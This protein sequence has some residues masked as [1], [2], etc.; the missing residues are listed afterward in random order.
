M[1]LQ[2]RRSRRRWKKSCIR[3]A[4]MIR[5]VLPS[6][7]QA[8]FPLVSS[9]L[10]SCCNG[11]PALPPSPKRTSDVAS[12]QPASCPPPITQVSRSLCRT[13]VSGWRTVG[14]EP[15]PSLWIINNKTQNDLTFPCKYS[16]V[17]YYFCFSLLLWYARVCVLLILMTHGWL[18]NSHL[19][20][21]YI[22]LHR[23][24]KYML[25]AYI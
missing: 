5:I 16:G 23:W 24:I 13:P 4:T 18:G 8:G 20:F 14:A 25:T 9:C 1:S 17:L 19:D 10:S 3:M 6:W 21:A 11:S 2:H 22:S 12:A 7:L 15:P